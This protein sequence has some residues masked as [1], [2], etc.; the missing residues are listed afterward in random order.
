MASELSNATPSMES[1]YLAAEAAR[2]M[3]PPYYQNL[4]RIYET[5]WNLLVETRG[6]AKSPEDELRRTESIVSRFPELRPA[7]DAL[8]ELTRKVFSTGRDF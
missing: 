6:E 3:L 8:S 2:G 4:I 7:V 1:Y 5:E